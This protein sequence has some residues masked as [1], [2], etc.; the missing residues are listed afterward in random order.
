VLKQDTIFF[1]GSPGSVKY[2]NGLTAH[3][4]HCHISF[5]QSNNASLV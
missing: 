1:K 2:R 4:R 5:K 3:L